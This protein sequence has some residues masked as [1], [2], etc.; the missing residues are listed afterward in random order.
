MPPSDPS[1][2]RKIC[3]VPIFRDRAFV[4]AIKI[5]PNCIYFVFLPK[6]YESTNCNNFTKWS[7]ILMEKQ[8][9]DKKHPPWP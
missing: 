4:Y 5:F 6:F 9:L 7:K 1:D 8:Q 2:R 3:A